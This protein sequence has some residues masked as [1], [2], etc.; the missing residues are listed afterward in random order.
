[1]KPTMTRS[2]RTRMGKGGVVVGTFGFSAVL[3]GG[4]VI[5]VGTGQSN[6]IQDWTKIDRAR[7][8]HTF[9]QLNDTAVFWFFRSLSSY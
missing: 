9:G 7:E 4:T 6:Q 8:P 1:M 3:A 2:I 5:N